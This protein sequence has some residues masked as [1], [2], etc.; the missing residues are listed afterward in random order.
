MFTLTSDER[1]TKLLKTIRQLEISLLMAHCETAKSDPVFYSGS[2][3]LARDVV[4]RLASLSPVVITKMQMMPSNLKCF[5]SRNFTIEQLKAGVSN[6]LEV[7]IHDD[8]P[9]CI[10]HLHILQ[11]R[12]LLLHRE[13]A[14]LAPAVA[15]ALLGLN[16]SGVLALAEIESGEILQINSIASMW[17]PPFK[18]VSQVDKFIKATAVAQTTQ[19]AIDL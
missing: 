12:L 16:R 13:M 3:N 10:F 1:V 14:L 4:S 7:R 5:F 15:S 8:V 19:Y 6:T 18:K 17:L 11:Q 2:T 9:S